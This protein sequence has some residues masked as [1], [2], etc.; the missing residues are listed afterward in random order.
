MRDRS[1]PKCEAQVV[2]LS[3]SFGEIAWL[4]KKIPQT[5]KFA[6]ITRNNFSRAD[7]QN[8]EVGGRNVPVAVFR[9]HVQIGAMN[10]VIRVSFAT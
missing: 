4:Q 5:L 9:R 1:W 8:N 7:A 10:L 2:R 3:V 6:V